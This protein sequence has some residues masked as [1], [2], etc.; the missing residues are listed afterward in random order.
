MNRQPRWAA[1]VTIAAAAAVAGC[2]ARTS[3]P[4]VASL[5][6]HTGSSGRPGTTLTQSQSDQDMVSFARCMRQHGVAMSDP[7][8]RPGHAGLSVDLPTRDA[9]TATAY[10]A[11]MRFLQPI[12]QMKEAGQ[13]SR[14]APDMAALTKYAECMRGHDIGMLDPL[15]DGELDLGNVPGITSDFGRHSPQFRAADTACR[16]LLPPGVQDDGTGP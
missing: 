14:A 8:H 5:S 7:V 1:L 3:A 15:S 6:G 9:A 2:S 11:C 16:H 4:P 13:A 10:T 12:I